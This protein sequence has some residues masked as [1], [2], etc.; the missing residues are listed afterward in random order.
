MPAVNMAPS[1]QGSN[2]KSAATRKQDNP[3]IDREQPPHGNEDVAEQV[4]TTKDGSRLRPRAKSN[5]FPM[6]AASPSGSARHGK[7]IGLRRPDN[8]QEALNNSVKR[9]GEEAHKHCT[10]P[11]TSPK[12]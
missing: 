6:S 7:H 4:K 5:H 9:H 3:I 8:L 1:R 11:F 12:L 2:D 10:P